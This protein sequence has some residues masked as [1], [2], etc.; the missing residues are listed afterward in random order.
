MITTF[1]SLAISITV[2]T[3]GT[4]QLNIKESLIFFAHRG[5][6]CE[7]TIFWDITPCSP[8]KFNLR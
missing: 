8:L 3:T 2:R 4:T 6:L 5:Y 1:S 7:E